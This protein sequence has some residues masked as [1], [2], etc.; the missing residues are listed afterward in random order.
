MLSTKANKRWRLW[1]G[2]SGAGPKMGVGAMAPS[3]LMQCR[4]M[5]K[6][7]TGTEGDLSGAAKR[8]V[9]ATLS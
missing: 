2:R 6:T 3:E 4:A 5:L 9:A 1:K 7:A 8:A